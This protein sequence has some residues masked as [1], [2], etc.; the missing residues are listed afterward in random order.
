MYDG[1]VELQFDPARHVYTVNGQV[2]DGVTGVTG[3]IDKS[4]P[5]M[6]WAVGQCLNYIRDHYHEEIDDVEFEEL[7]AEARRAH[8]RSS[9]KAATIGHKAHA[10][11]EQWI[12]GEDPLPPRNSNVRASIDSFLA[13]AKEVD[14]Q[15]IE[16]EFK[17]YSQSHNYAGT[18]D[19][20]G[21]LVYN[22]TTERVIADWKTGSNV[23][24]EHAFQT[25]AYQLARQEEG[26]ANYDSRWVVV[27]PKDGGD[28]IAQRFGPETDDCHRTGF[29]SALSLRRA[30][31]RWN[32]RESHE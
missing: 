10:W 16:T 21:T 7:L 19:F 18:C 5:L 30:L 1:R 3:V 15:P 17:C 29:L 28:I 26:I 12:R 4:G 32:R 24:S 25:A 11:I 6:W 13:W 14:L 8:S 23:Y 2:V 22:G 31:Q 27:L 20:D 9:R